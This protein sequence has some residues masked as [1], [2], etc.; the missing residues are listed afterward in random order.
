MGNLTDDMTR[1]RG[2]VDALRSTRGALM[3]EL[4]H[5]ASDLAAAVAS[6]RADFTAAHQ[7]M[8]RKTGEERNAF[9]AAVISEV[10]TLL[11]DFSKD[12]SD[13]ARKGRHDRGIFLAEMK[14]QVT[15]MCKETADDMM[16]ARLAWRGQ[17]SRKS[18][19]VQTKSVQLRKEPELT[20]P[21]KQPVEE[22]IKK[23]VAAPEFKA[24]KLPAT[25]NEPLKKEEKQEV[26]AKPEFTAEPPPVTS[27]EPL[28]KEAEKK[29]A[30]PAPPEVE[31]PK[32]KMPPPA[33]AS[34]ETPKQNEKRRLDE[35]PAKT[36]SRGKRGKK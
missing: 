7:A 12:R 35:K 22:P 26:V 5:G 3:Q 30:A 28:K 34:P 6:M 29:A 15:G 31:P 18:S 24:D 25:F 19:P 14:R 8:A 9:V 11:G 27:M 33:F 1:L 4:A 2:E 13:M 36:A 20:A 32:V 17:I 10:N 23:A 16:G 21:V